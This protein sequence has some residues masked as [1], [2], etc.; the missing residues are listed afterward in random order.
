[1]RAIPLILLLLVMTFIGRGQD[2]NMHKYLDVNLHFTSKKHAAYQ[3][4]ATP[5]GNHWILQAMY[6]DGSVV[7][8]MSFADKQL[9][10]KDGSYTVYYSNGKIWLEGYFVND[11]ATGRWQSWY[12]NGQVHD[13]GRISGNHFSGQW[14]HWYPGGQLKKMNGYLPFTVKS[15]FATPPDSSS[16]VATVDVI[17]TLT[18]GYLTISGISDG[19]WQSWY[20]NG[21]PESDGMASHGLPTGVWKWFRE[22]GQLSSIETYSG[23]K[24]IQLECYDERGVLTGNT[25]SI[26]KPAV[27]THPTLSAGQYIARALAQQYNLNR[28]DV[29]RIQIRFTI[30][31]TGKIEEIL[32]PRFDDSNIQY[33][34]LAVLSNMPAWSPAISHNRS[35]DYPVS[36][37]IY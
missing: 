34:I 28:H 3:A 36:I 7:L 33:I 35:I 10:I 8:R 29:G 14:K 32:I 11:S 2:I 13:S 22:N 16:H 9:T 26:L 1:M 37:N 24:I 20:E 6:P 17:D 18:A 21:Q 19:R 4:T 12:G 31:K 15:P 30:T 27:F 25:C 23:G 5:D